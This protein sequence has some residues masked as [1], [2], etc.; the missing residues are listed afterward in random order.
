[1]PNTYTLIADRAP[2]GL[3]DDLAS[4]RLTGFDNGVSLLFADGSLAPEHLATR[5]TCYFNERSFF[6]LFHGTYERLRLAPAATSTEPSGKTMKLWELSDVF[7]VFIGPEARTSRRYKEFQAS[8]DGRWIDID[9]LNEPGRR[10]DYE[11][12]SGV[13]IVST[14]DHLLQRWYC[15]FEI[16]WS[17][18]GGFVPELHG[19]FYRATGRFHGD[20]LLAWSPPGTGERC[21]HRSECFGTIRCDV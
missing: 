18:L 12:V 13:K 1:M 17:G 5:V 21:F 3:L 6:A 8:P 10:A 9:V 20:E 16:P 19:N 7:E 11:W 15:A 2:F 4:P 14:V